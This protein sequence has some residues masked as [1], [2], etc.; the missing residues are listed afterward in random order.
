MGGLH[1]GRSHIAVSFSC[2]PAESFPRALLLPRTNTS[3][4]T[5]VLSIWEALHVRSDLCHQDVQ[6]LLAHPIDLFTALDLLFKRLQMPFD[7]CFQVLDRTILHL[8]EGK[9][10][11]QQKAMVLSHFYC[12][13][14]D[15][16]LLGGMDTVMHEPG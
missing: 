1:Q 10:L 3:P 5:E 11:A 14:G 8:N 6:D 9:Q 12:Q 4:R 13:R 15:H 16:F 2:S 7:L